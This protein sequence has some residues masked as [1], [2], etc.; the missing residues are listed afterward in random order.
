MTGSGHAGGGEAGVPVDAG[1]AGTAGSGANRPA[2]AA[3]V[4]GKV[5]RF[6]VPGLLVLATVIGIAATFA[7]W[8]NRQALDTS[9]WSATSSKILQDEQVQTALSAYLVRELYLQCGR[10]GGV[11]DGVA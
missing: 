5:H 7:I 6:V 11:A 3:G 10:V 4:S 8:V 9:N 1:P 2:G